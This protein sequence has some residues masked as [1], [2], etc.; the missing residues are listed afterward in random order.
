MLAA[1]TIIAPSL[2]YALIEKAAKT[3]HY[4]FKGL[5]VVED[6]I[7]GG[8]RRFLWMAALVNHNHEIAL[9]IDFKTKQ[10]SYG[11]LKQLL[12]LISIYQKNTGDSL[13]GNYP[14]PVELVASIQKWLWA[15]FHG[16][17]EELGDV[18]VHGFQKD[19][20]SCLIC[21][22]NTIAHGVFG[23]MLWQP[24]KRGNARANW[25]SRLIQPRFRHVS[26]S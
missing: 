8:K 15:R 13:A 9:R 5:R 21:T 12:S 24:S 22:G 6:L 16:P 23:D 1:S 10:I 17:F 7:N 19:G 14:P 18:L 3:K 2:F 25:F 4:N 26:I 11:M 20:F